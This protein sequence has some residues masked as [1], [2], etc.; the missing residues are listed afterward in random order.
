MIAADVCG[1]VELAFERRGARTVLARSRTEAPMLVVR[2]FPLPDGGLAVQLITL[3]P[4]LC[5]GDIMRIDVTADEGTR[6][7]VTTTAASRVMS[8]EPGSHAEQHVALRA[9]AG[10]TLEY[11]PAASIPF[12]G[13]DFRQTVRVD[14]APESRVGVL[15]SWALGRPAREERLE[16]RRISSRTALRVDGAEKYLDATELEPPSSSLDSV[17][18]LAGYSYMASGFWYGAQLP[19]REIEPLQSHS[20]HELV[21]AAFAQSSPGLV[22]LRALARDAPAMNDVLRDTTDQIACAWS[23]APLRVER[24]KCLEA[25]KPNTRA[26]A[27]GTPQSPRRGPRCARARDRCARRE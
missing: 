21:L 5:G 9:A 25:A 6:V 10:A 11:Y 14:A 4:G 7:L 2:P 19:V 15:E 8:M 26:R 1:C 17:A 13:S 18:I 22:Y 3:G 24:F 12:P 16:F 20:G 23:V 27:S